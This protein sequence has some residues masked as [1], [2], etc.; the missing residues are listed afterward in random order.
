MSEP[1]ST[2]S[3]QV[4]NLVPFMPH[5]VE[6]TGLDFGF[7]AD[8]TLKIVYSDSQSTTERV[9]ER[10]KLPMLITETLLQ[11]LYH[12]KL[13][14][15]RGTAGFRN[16]RYTMLDHGWERVRRLLELSGY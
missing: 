2:E 10:L 4:E 16:D 12:E 9:A 15:I 7:L 1:E 6:G 3:L 13:V 8:L 11:Y 5:N 14:D